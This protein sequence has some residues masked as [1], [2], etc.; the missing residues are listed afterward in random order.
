MAQFELDS[1][2]FFFKNKYCKLDIQKHS[3]ADTETVQKK[4]IATETAH[5]SSPTYNYFMCIFFTK[6][7]C[8]YNLFFILSY[9]QCK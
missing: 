2:L 9:T 4:T 7:Q 1:Y 8:F 5:H 3:T 6:F